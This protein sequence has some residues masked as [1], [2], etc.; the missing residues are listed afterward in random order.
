MNSQVERNAYAKKKRTEPLK[1]PISSRG[2]RE[3]N[4]KLGKRGEREPEYP[5]LSPGKHRGEGGGGGEEGNYEW[6]ASWSGGGGGGG[7][8]GWGKKK[9]PLRRFRE[10]KGRGGLAA[11]RRCELRKGL[12]SPGVALL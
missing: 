12:P 5:Q 4:V 6:R 1:D 11:A 8:P 10:K 9:H 2:E 3:V 7:P